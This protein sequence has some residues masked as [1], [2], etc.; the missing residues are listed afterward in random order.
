MDS[1]SNVATGNDSAKG[2]E[3]PAVLSLW[4]D[5][6]VFL[7]FELRYV[8]SFVLLGVCFLILRGASATRLTPS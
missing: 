7:P 6:S 1:R 3:C 5:P 4:E 8:V 2:S